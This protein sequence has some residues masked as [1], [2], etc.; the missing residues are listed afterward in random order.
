MKL[1]HIKAS[2]RDERSHSL[3]AAKG[4]LASLRKRCSSIEVTEL[5]VWQADLPSFDGALLDAKYAR[6]A[7]R[8]F[9]EE[10][11]NAWGKVES[12]VRELD[13]AEIVLISTPMWNLSIP[14][15]LKHYIDLVTQPG[16]SFIFDPQTGYTPLLG[17]RPVFAILASSGDFADGPS[18]GR[19]DLASS[20][21]RQ[22]LKFIG[23]VDAEIVLL[24][25]TI[26]SGEAVQAA[27]DLVQEK[28]TSFVDQLVGT[29]G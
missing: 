7:R 22:A 14:Y 3:R 8:E 29:Q 23:L 9:T 11:A 20:Y 5:D 2:P 26:G 12:L 24:G 1:L 25:P 28:L 19:P 17:S 21:L 16:V 13:D 15:R 27:A 4:F 10:Q 6:L 18:W